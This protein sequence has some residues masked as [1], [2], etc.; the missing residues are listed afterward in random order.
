MKEMKWIYA[1]AFLCAVYLQIS[2]GIALNIPI[3][4]QV[5]FFLWFLVLSFICFRF[6]EKTEDWKENL[7]EV[8]TPITLFII[9]YFSFKGY[10]EYSGVWE[11]IL[12]VV[13]YQVFLVCLSGIRKGV[14]SISSLLGF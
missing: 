6:M 10:L 5:L 2:Q 12:M 9:N 13:L 7:G 11:F 14:N 4:I 1:V 8:I 3:W